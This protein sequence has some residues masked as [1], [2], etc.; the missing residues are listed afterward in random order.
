[1]TQAEKGV[2][3]IVAGCTIWGFAP[4]YYH[5]LAHVSA[6]EMMAHRTVW[7]ALSF[8]LLLAAQG[9]FGQVL[10]LWRG[11]ERGRVILSSL[12]IGFNWLLFI[13]A[14]GVGRAVEAGIAYYIFPLISAVIGMA[15]FRERPQGAQLVA[16]ALAGL[17]VG[18][19]T[20]GLGVAPWIALTLAISFAG[21]AAVKKGMA[22]GAVTSVTLEVLLLLPLAL[23]V[24]VWAE[25][26]AWGPEHGWLLRDGLHAAVLP[27]SGLISG[28]PL[29]LFSWGA[30]RVRLVTSGLV[31]Y[32]NPT[33][34]VLSAV[35]IIGEGFTRW[36]GLALAMIWAALALYSASA[37]AAD[38]AARRA[39]SAETEGSTVI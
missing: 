27:L 8:S 13:W 5:A 34:Q 1:M 26:G 18:V 4:L 17:A 3:A 19:L 35:V 38:R 33:L 25:S 28:G 23:G 14:I 30:Q 15:V 31:Q 9:R 2:L 6:L 37:W 11:P 10:A 7:T 24:L 20:L 16:V 32:V 22:A 21:Y 12:L 39:S 29:I 36:H